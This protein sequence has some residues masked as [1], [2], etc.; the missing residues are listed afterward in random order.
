MERSKLYAKYAEQLPCKADKLE[1][2]LD[3]PDCG[4][5]RMHFIVN[6]EEK[7]LIEASSVYEPFEDI[8]D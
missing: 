6:D 5:L 3:Y 7:L 2:Q 4:W 8:R 1:L